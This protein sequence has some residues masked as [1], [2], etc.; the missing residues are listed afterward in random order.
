MSSGQVQRALLANPGQ[1]TCYR[2][3]PLTSLLGPDSMKRGSD[4]YSHSQG[5]NLLGGWGRSLRGRGQGH[6]QAA[7]THTPLGSC[8]FV[9]SFSKLL[10]MFS[11]CVRKGQGSCTWEVGLDLGSTHCDLPWAS[12]SLGTSHTLGNIPYSSI[13]YCLLLGKLINWV[14]H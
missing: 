9:T 14:S 4:R 3:R 13:L 1:S 2:Q 6:S 5:P 7:H 10:I 11:F 8:P 12:S